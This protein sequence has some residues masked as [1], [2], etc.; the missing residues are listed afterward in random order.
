M[1]SKILLEIDVL[2]KR[3]GQDPV[4]LLYPGCNN[5]FFRLALMRKVAEIGIDAEN[6][7]YEDAKSKQQTP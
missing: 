1:T 4:E 6:Q 2:A 5:P 7:A 3:Y